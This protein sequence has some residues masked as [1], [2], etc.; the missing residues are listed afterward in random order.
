M[1]MYKNVNQGP[2][3]I[4]KETNIRKIHSSLLAA[5]GRI[6]KQEIIFIYINLI[7][8]FCQR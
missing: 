6:H 1:T 2:E 4:K 8:V 7:Q 5:Y 3:E